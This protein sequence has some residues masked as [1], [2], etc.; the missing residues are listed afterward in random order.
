[1]RDHHHLGPHPDAP[2]PRDPPPALPRLAAGTRD[3]TPLVERTRRDALEV[4]QLV[5]DLK[6]PLATIALELLLLER[7]P[8][9]P[10][11]RGKLD[12]VRANVA[13]L[14]RL[15]H[16]ILDAGAD[17]AGTLALRREPTKV[18]ALLASIIE[19]AVPATD[20]ARVVLDCSREIELAIDRLRIERVVCNLLQNA[21]KYS[22]AETRV[23]VHLSVTPRRVRISVLD[24][25]PGLSEAAAAT[26]F[27]PYRRGTTTHEGHGLGLYLSRKLVEAHGGRLGVRSSRGVG[28]CFYVDLPR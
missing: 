12:R 3:L 8:L 13:F 10:S 23:V 11:V 21:L 9:A 4:G 6:N 26:V 14:E 16:E 15:V 24:A 17:G 28:S 7:E 25:G 18:R 1:M 27:E 20:R 2:L 5:H 22:P 19:R